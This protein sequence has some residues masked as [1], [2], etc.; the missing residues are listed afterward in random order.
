M[1]LLHFSDEHGNEYVVIT[2]RM[3]Q[4][5]LIDNTKQGYKL[6]GSYRLTPVNGKAHTL[7]CDVPMDSG[8]SLSA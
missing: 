6:E 7:P 1:F 8:R 3:S 2:P 4:A 5:N